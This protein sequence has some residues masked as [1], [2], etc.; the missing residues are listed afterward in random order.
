MGKL[1]LILIVCFSL[2]V[3]IIGGCSP[4]TWEIEVEN[5]SGQ[6]LYEGTVSSSGKSFLFGA[7]LTAGVSGYGNANNLFGKDIPNEMVLSFES[8][9]GEKFSRRVVMSGSGKNGLRLVINTK[10]EVTG[11]YQ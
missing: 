3:A 8:A 7:L 5:Q 2:F 9:S 4:K 6:E 10:L 1:Y 11:K